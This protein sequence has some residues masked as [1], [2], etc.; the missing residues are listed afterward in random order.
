[1]KSI[2]KAGRNTSGVKIVNIEGEDYVVSIARCPKEES[3]LDTEDSIG[4]INNNILNLSDKKE[5]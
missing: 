4:E 1:M 2:R 3:E 5:E